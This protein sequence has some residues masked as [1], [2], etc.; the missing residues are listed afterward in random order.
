[1]FMIRLLDRLHLLA[2][3]SRNPVKTGVCSEEEFR[4][5]I[6]V[7]RCRAERTRLSFAVLQVACAH[8][9]AGGNGTGALLDRVAEGFLRRTRRTDVVGWLGRDALGVLLPYTRGRDAWRLV[10]EVQ[11]N[12][13]GPSGNGGAPKLLCRVF[14]YPFEGRDDASVAGEMPEPEPQDHL[15]TTGAHL[16]PD[17]E[18][19]RGQS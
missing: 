1:M 5:A 16:F 19:W 11:A 4:R 7:E 13:A 3:G 6:D 18:P 15:Q 8:D 10:H 17:H 14:V 9:A 2:P 12:L